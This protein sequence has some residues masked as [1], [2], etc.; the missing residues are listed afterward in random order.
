MKK[1]CVAVFLAAL[2]ALPVSNPVQAE[3]VLSLSA[4]SAVLMDASN[5]RI[6]YAK[7]PDEQL[8]MASTTKIMTA[9]LTLEEAAKENK[10]VKITREMVQVEGSSM[11]LKEG[12][13]LTLWDL[14]AGMLA[15][16]GNDAANSAAIAVSGSKEAFA[17]EMNRKARELGMENSHFVTPSGLD[18]QE[19][20]STARD[21][22]VLACR[23]LENREFA[24]IVSEPAIRVTYRSPEQSRVLTN[25]N[26]LLRMYDGCIGVKTGFTKKAGRCLVSAAEREGVRLVAVTLNAP[27]D[28]N[29]HMTMFDYGFSKTALYTPD[30]SGY[31]ISVPVVGGEAASVAVRGE[32]GTPVSLLKEE[33]TVLER[34]VELPR[35][36]YAGIEKGQTVGRVVYL[37]ENEEIASVPLK[38]ETS[39]ELAKREKTIWER[40]GGWFAGI[41]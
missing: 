16:S 12:D 24:A 34:R 6:L 33:E 2:F 28:W 18:D 40:I 30:E 17:G 1:K 35:F 41:F 19:H 31:R 4:E 27:D 39:V 20:Y 14:A 32:E 22:A 8:A 13:V 3:E 21:M 5:G 25:H 15:V 38:T 10:E 9:L 7:N 29:D 37:L 23:A 11:G 26:K 36:L